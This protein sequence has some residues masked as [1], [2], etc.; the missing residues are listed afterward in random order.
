MAKNR[1]DSDQSIE[2]LL[3]S[4]RKA[5][6]D[7]KAWQDNNKNIGADHSHSKKKDTLDYVVRDDNHKQNLAYSEASR[8]FG[9]INNNSIAEYSN[10][11]E[12][13]KNIHNQP[14]NRT[15]D[16]RHVGL[17]SDH[18]KLGYEEQRFINNANLVDENRKQDNNI[19]NVIIN[20]EQENEKRLFENLF[21][22]DFP[23]EI[24]NREN[25]FS[26]QIS[27]DDRENQ[28]RYLENALE[29][30][31]EKF[32]NSKE[33]DLMYLI[34]EWIK[35]HSSKIMERVIRE[36]VQEKLSKIFKAKE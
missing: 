10:N 28:T 14:D 22:K 3:K 21:S 6:E 24:S 27:E 30:S 4:I 18:N 19:R 23:D 36:E 34:Q 5:I 33:A 9:Y 11:K 15:T 7:D 26:R 12:I 32:I 8:D 29:K 25:N 31:I 13:F 35:M 1:E 2:V 17:K 20:D 16:L